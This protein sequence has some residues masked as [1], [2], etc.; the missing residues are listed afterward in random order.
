M[1]AKLASPSR[2]AFLEDGPLLEPAMR[3]LFNVPGSGSFVIAMGLASGYPIGAVLTARMRREGLVTREE[4]ERLM[5]FANTADPLFMAG[6]VAVGMFGNAR[7]AGLIMAAHY[8]GALATGIL[9]ARAL[10]ALVDARQRDGRP[11]GRLLGEAVRDSVNTLLLIGGFI[12]L[13][14]V[15]I[16]L[17]RETGLLGGMAAVLSWPLGRVGIDPATLPGIVSG[18]FEI[19]IGTQAVAGAEA[20]LLQRTVAASAVIAWS[21]L[22]VLGQVAAIVQGTDIRLAPYIVARAVHAL[23]AAIAVALFDPQ[24]HLAAIP[25]AFPRAGRT[26]SWPRRLR[27]P[28]PAAGGT[29]SSSRPRRSSPPASPCSCSPLP[30]RRCTGCTPRPG[31]RAAGMAVAPE[32]AEPGGSQPGRRG[33]GAGSSSGREWGTPISSRACRTTLAHFWMLPSS[34]SSTVAAYSRAPS[35]ISRLCRRA[36]SRMRAASS[37]ARWVMTDSLVS[38][39]ARARASL[40]MA[41]ASSRAWARIR[42]RSRTTRCACWIPSGIALRSRSTRPYRRSM[43]TTILLVRGMWGASSSS[44]SISSNSAFRS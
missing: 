34:L 1:R 33:S 4:A 31:G 24:E 23:A 36:S 40:M 15:I 13:F 8:L 5:S 10:G 9:P 35:L 18:V 20:S 30:P 21:G 17:L 11:L 32:P 38:F 43:S 6:A 42:S 25:A 2:R 14:S 27:L 16:Q 37:S 44:S 3:P 29:G 41:S 28:R 12:V 22:S 26:P 39:S 19:T 7:L